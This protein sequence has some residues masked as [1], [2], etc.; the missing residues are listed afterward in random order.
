M[1]KAK[2]LI[3]IKRKFSEPFKKQIVE[4]YEMGR[5]SVSELSRLHQIAS[6]VVYGWIY[7]YSHYNQQKVRII[8]MTKSSTYK[9]GELE[10]RIKELEQIVGQKQ[11]KID[12]LEKMIE[13]A[14]DDLGVN[15][16]KKLEARHSV[17][18]EK[19]EKK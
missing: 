5:Y 3:S 10:K 2:K 19:T 16:K 17:I 9:L 12:Y 13:I 1:V 14:S 8:E 18:S 15:I 6:K 4:D 7:K 11:I